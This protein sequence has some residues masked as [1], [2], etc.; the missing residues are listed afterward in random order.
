MGLF[1]LGLAT[2]SAS[3]SD[4]SNVKS[5]DQLLLE[6]VEKSDTVQV[7]V[8]IK[9][10]ANVDAAR[11]GDRATPLI[12]ASNKGCV[13]I[14]EKLIEAGAD[15]NAKNRNGWTALMGASSNGHL[16]I[17]TLLVTARADVNAKHSYGWTALKLA[18]QKGHTQVRGLLLRNGAKE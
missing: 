3:A 9:E 10:G 14:V 8:L 11:E 17:A 4:S 2:D 1:L 13:Q 7:T 12:L 5:K 15:V 16:N 6:S 18:S